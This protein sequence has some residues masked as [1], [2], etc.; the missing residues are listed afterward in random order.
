[1]VS[2]VELLILNQSPF[3]LLNKRRLTVT[4]R[5]VQDMKSEGRNRYHNT[6]N[7]NYKCVNLH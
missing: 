1:M 5:D 3:Q 6:P 7:Y 2:N 4:D